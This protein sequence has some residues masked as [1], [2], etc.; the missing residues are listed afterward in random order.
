[1]KTSNKVDSA[2]EVFSKFKKRVYSG[3]SSDFS[4]ISID[5]GTHTGVAYWEYS[6]VDVP[7]EVFTINFHQ[8][9]GRI[10]DK[11]KWMSEEFCEW[12]GNKVTRQ[13]KLKKP[14]IVFLE[15]VELW[16]TSAKSSAAGSKGDLSA[17]AYLVGAYFRIVTVQGIECITVKPTEWKGQMS[18]AI[19]KKRIERVL[20]SEMPKCSV[21]ARSA[22]GIKLA[23][24]GRL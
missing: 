3:I 24:T 23:L 7:D 4:V 8:D 5:P 2:L 17:L 16:N 11:L 21:H 15:G 20:T 12:F 9:Q 22:I 10:E 19:V 13:K 6:F 1:M 14:L 18:D